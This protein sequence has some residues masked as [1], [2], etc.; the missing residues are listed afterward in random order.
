[1]RFSRTRG[2]HS[3]ENPPNGAVI[4]Y[5]F[6]NEPEGDVALE[7]L[8]RDGAVLRRYSSRPSGRKPP[9]PAFGTPADPVVPKEKGMNRFVWNLTYPGPNLTD[10]AL[11]YIGYS[12]G[13]V[14]VP[15][16]YQVN[17]SYGDFS[18]TAPF[19]LLKDPRVATTIADYQ[20][21]F[22][23]LIQ[24]RDKLT[25]THDVIRSI[26][27]VRQQVEALSKRLVEAGQGE[28]V[29]TAAEALEGELTVLEKEL[30]Q[31]KNEAHQ[32]PINFPPQ[33]DTRFGFL[34]GY[35]HRL[36]GKPTAGTYDRF[37]DLKP[38]LAEKL[39]RFKDLKENELAALNT[40]VQ[41]KGVLPVIVGR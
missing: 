38:R 32:D 12:G 28:G 13:P 29:E 19:E 15:G 6:E 18:A 31:T 41:E 10:D 20:E 17:L 21:Q 40:L 3:P 1:M 7:I 23:L 9:K 14:A 36:N 30:I 35:V 22:D 34:Y 37:H 27:D 33:L 5:T 16:T 39:A 11:M 24:I 25:E 2:A 4:F 8:D 26:R